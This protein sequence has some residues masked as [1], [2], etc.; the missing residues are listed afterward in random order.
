HLV[1]Q[2]RTDR[3]APDS[4]LRTAD[5]AQVYKIV[6]HRF[7]GIDGDGKADARTLL[8]ASGQDHGV[9]SDLLR[10]RVQQRAAGIAGI[11][12]RIGL[13]SF[14]NEA[15]RSTDRADGADDAA[16]HGAAQAKWVADGKHLLPDHQVLGVT[17]LNLRHALGWNLD[18]CQIVH[19]IGAHDL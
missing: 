8:G 14:V 11:D 9:D 3:N 5:A 4:Q 15:A 17:D 1:G 18:Y 6:E 10:T 12:G 16:R 19:R 7:R 2:L 13:D